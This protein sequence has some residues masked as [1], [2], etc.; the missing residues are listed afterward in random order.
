[1]FFPQIL[2]SVFGGK[3]C[4][5][6]YALLKG[7]Q[8]QCTS[9]SLSWHA[10]T[11]CENVTFIGNNMIVTANSCVIDR[12]LLGI[13]GGLIPLNLYFDSGAIEL[14]N[15]DN[16]TQLIPFKSLQLCNDSNTI[17][18]FSKSET[19]NSKIVFHKYND[20]AEL[21]EF[22]CD[23]H[24][25]EIKKIIDFFPSISSHL[26]YD[27]QCSKVHYISLNGKEV[28]SFEHGKE[29]TTV[30][31]EMQNITVESVINLPSLLPFCN[32]GWAHWVS[33]SS[34]EN[35]VE[36]VVSSYTLHIDR[37]EV[38]GHTLSCVEYV[39]ECD[40]LKETS[41]ASFFINNQKLL[42]DVE[43]D[44]VTNSG[45]ITIHSLCC[46]NPIIAHIEKS[47][48]NTYNF[49]VQSDQLFSWLLPS[50]F[51]V[52][53]GIL[54]GSCSFSFDK[55]GHFNLAICSQELPSVLNT[56]VSIDLHKDA[57]SIRADTT[58]CGK[59]TLPTQ[60]HTLSQP[61]FIMPSQL[62]IQSKINLPEGESLHKGS[63]ILLPQDGVKVSLVHS[64]KCAYSSTNNTTDITNETF[65]Y[66]S[67]DGNDS[68]L[69]IKNAMYLHP[70]IGD[71][72]CCID[73]TTNLG[74]VVI[75]SKSNYSSLEIYENQHTYQGTAS[76]L[77]SPD[78]ALQMAQVTG[79]EFVTDNTFISCSLNESSSS[80]TTSI[81]ALPQMRYAC[82]YEDDCLLKSNT[83]I[84]VSDLSVT[85]FGDRFE[86]SM[87]V[88]ISELFPVAVTM[89]GKN[90]DSIDLIEV[91][92]FGHKESFNVAQDDT[93]F[94]DLIV[95]HYL[96]SLLVYF[97][98]SA[99]AI[100]E[101]TALKNFSLKKRASL[102][103]RSLSHTHNL[104]RD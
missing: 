91:E 42:F 94:I 14:I 3:N 35:G 78:I 15:N 73:T 51:Q 20:K 62:S 75:T 53:D 101:L 90:L 10:E 100:K 84:S 99:I 79:L 67:L 36:A 26:P 9:I 17:T 69:I 41:S 58:A 33:K 34:S 80:K 44:K 83:L 47:E 56:D 74:G 52:S 16:T 2:S 102:T 29:K 1:M 92:A 61:N 60:C 72:K 13:L 98:E 25:S 21:I 39:H 19:S 45:E 12:G 87:Q 46:N 66:S 57:V 104:Q 49:E 37:C 38:S 103:P 97:E 27:I 54:R 63:V 76:F 50:L 96:D 4:A 70:I 43:Y 55:L 30:I 32:K 93:P 18:A 64:E 71:W 88:E 24:Y 59:L 68:E 77:L 86:A 95:Q 8:F 81:K 22:L 7:H 40:T 89:K 85:Q 65:S 23:G 6:V 11:K 31:K 82:L 48:P 5:T 28:I